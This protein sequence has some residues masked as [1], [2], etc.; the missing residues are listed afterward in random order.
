TEAQ[1]EYACR[2]GTTSAYSFGSS[3]NGREAN[4]NGRYPY[5]TSTK[6]PYLEKTVPVKSYAPNAWGLYDMHGNVWEWC[7]D[8]YASNYYAASPTSDPCN[9]DSGSNRVNRGGSWS[10]YAQ[11]CRSAYR[12]R[13]SPDVRFNCLGFRPVLASPVPEE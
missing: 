6:G 13:N 1:W 7:Q 8:K 12:S 5:G 4:C 2:A 9:E 10:N 11:F 3:L